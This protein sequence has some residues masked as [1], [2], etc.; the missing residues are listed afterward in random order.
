[1]TQSL[2]AQT[3][4]ARWLALARIVAGAMWLGHAVPKFITS[5]TFMPPNGAIVNLVTQGSQHGSHYVAPFLAGVVL[6]NISLFAEL[7]RLGELLTGIALV[8]GLFTRLGGLAGMFLTVMYASA[9]GPLFSLDVLSGNDFA[10]F[11]LSGINLV[12]PTGRA[13]GLDALMSRRRAR[14]ARV[15][16]EF[17]QEPPLIT[18]PPSTEPPSGISS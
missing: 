2:P 9:K 4:Y 10:M 1:M 15:H 6:P 8:L 17:V 14:L 12:L 13:F 16:A 7:V 18:P 11:T 3:T 5:D